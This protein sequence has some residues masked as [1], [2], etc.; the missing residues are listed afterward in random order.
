M[1]TVVQED[2]TEEQVEETY[3]VTVPLST[4]EVYET[5][6]TWRGCVVSDEERSNAADI[7]AIVMGSMGGED[8]S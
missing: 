7:Y 1:V 5:L 2:G 6:S 4:A 3:A 8:F